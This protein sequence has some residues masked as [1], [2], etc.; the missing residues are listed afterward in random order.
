MKQSKVD[1]EEQN[2]LDLAPV[3]LAEH[4]E[5]DGCVV[6]L[7]P[8]PQSRGLRRLLDRMIWVLSTQRIRLDTIG[9]FAWHRLDGHA[10]VAEIAA[11]VRREFGVEAE[12]VEERLGRLM[13]MLYG[14]DW[15]AY[16]GI[17]APSRI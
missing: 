11:E 2:L 17:D 15:I 7:R 14:E 16:P 9:S 6:I 1:L 12:P 13:Q 4:E 10:T 3:R 5:K 8:R